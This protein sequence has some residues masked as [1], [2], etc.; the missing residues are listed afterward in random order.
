MPE[1]DTEGPGIPL[2]ARNTPNDVGP[3]ADGGEVALGAAAYAGVVWTTDVQAEVAVLAGEGSGMVVLPDGASATR[4][5]TVGRPLCTIPGG[6][7]CPEGSPGA[8]AVFRLVPKGEMTVAVTGGP[9]DN[10]ATLLGFS[11]EDFCARETCPVGSWVSIRWEVP[12]IDIAFG[13]GTMILTIDS[14]LDSVVEFDPDFPLYAIAESEGAVRVKL[15]FDGSYGF[16]IGTL[17]VPTGSARVTTYA[18]LG[19]EWVQTA[20]PIDLTSGGM[21]YIADSN[22]TCEGDELIVTSV[23]PVGGRLIFI[24]WP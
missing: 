5:D 1:W 3:L 24:A 15:V 11:L 9:A 19:G 4:A 20:E 8:S 17:G 16:K 2:A 23:D 12:N 7:T 10:L 18:D 14:Q 6:C 22:F 13:A 21:G